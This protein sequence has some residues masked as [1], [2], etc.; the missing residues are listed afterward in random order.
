MP[1][2]VGFTEFRYAKNKN[3]LGA[4]VNRYAREGY[5]LLIVYERGTFF[6]PKWDIKGGIGIGP[7]G[8]RASPYNTLLSNSSFYFHNTKHLVLNIEP[9]NDLFNSP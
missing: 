9:D 4:K 1:V 3:I 8:G 2:F 7:R 5:H 6:L